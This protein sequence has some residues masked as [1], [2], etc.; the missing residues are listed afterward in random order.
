MNLETHEPR[1]NSWATG[2][3]HWLRGDSNRVVTMTL[4]CRATIGGTE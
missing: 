1:N 3:H 4:C 2:Y